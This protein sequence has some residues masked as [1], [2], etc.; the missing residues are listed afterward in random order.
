MEHT[1]TELT[2][3]NFN[4]EIETYKG[5]ALVDFWAPWC[6]PCRMVGPIIEQLANEY[7]GKAKI[8]KINVDENQEVPEKFGIQ[9]IP[10]ML[11]FKDGKLVDSLVGAV[12][13]ATIEE[14]LKNSL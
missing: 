6:G 12:P 14:K 10:T 2:D 5:T 13:K 3:K 9:G 1:Y 11:F 7:Q 8:C 4:Q